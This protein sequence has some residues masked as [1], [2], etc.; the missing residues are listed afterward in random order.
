MG[1]TKRHVAA[2][3]FQAFGKTVLIS[4]LAQMI[5][6]TQKQVKVLILEPTRSLAHRHRKKYFAHFVGCLLG[7]EIFDVD[8]NGAA[9]TTHQE[10]LDSCH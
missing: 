10:F 6:K 9:F 3:I 4:A 8:V 1:F 2:E 5:A 7:N